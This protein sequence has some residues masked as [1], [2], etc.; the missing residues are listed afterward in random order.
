[1]YLIDSKE[2]TIKKVETKTFSELGIRERDHLQEWIAKNPDCFGEPLLIIQ[3]EFDGFSDTAERLDLL[4]IDKSGNLVIIENKLDDSGRDV[5]WQSLKYASYCSTLS[6]SDII[7]IFQTYLDKQGLIARADFI[8]SEFFDG[9]DISEIQINPAL[10][11]RIILVAAKFR[12]EVTSTV[13]WLMNFRI[14]F[15]CF[16]T[17]AFKLGDQLLITFDQIIPTKD[18]EDFMI[19]MASKASVDA[20]EQKELKNRHVLRRKFW[21]KLLASMNK[22]S[23][24]FQSVNPQ[25]SNWIARG[26]GTSG[27][28]YNFG[29]SQDYARVELYIDKGIKEINESIFVYLASR[30]V[31]I[32]QSFGE[33]LTWELLEEKRACR[34]KCEMLTDGFDEANWDLMIEFLV[35]RM[36]KLESA[37]K[38]FVDDAVTHA[39]AKTE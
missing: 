24:L 2:N 37:F 15:Q 19:G 28:T 23:A 17:S 25:S 13:L 20:G 9:M 33:S 4:A 16:R 36:I 21:A 29:F 6:K 39:L 31:E 30:K 11:Q 35:P 34:I 5:T 3:K 14:Q 8:L 27:I 38:P 18:A 12:K 10:S 32:E 26:S 7:S 1:M 22:K